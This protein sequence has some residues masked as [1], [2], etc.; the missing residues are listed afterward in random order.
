MIRVASPAENRARAQ[1][2]IVTLV[3]VLLSFLLGATVCA[4]WLNRGTQRT[5]AKPESE[6]QGTPPLELS[7]TT[8]AILKRLNSPLEIRFYSLLDPAT[9]DEATR[10]FASRT[11]Q[12]L[13][14][15]QQE[16]QGKITVAKSS[17]QSYAAA[18]AA[19]ADGVKP[20]NTEKGEPCFLGLAVLRNGQKESLS[21]LSPEWETVLEADISRAI[22]RVMDSHAPGAPA[23]TAPGIDSATAEEVKHSLTNLDSISL[24]DGTRV[25]REAALKQFKA[26]VVELQ[27]ELEQAQQELTRAQGSGSEAEQQA[28]MKHLQQVQARQSDQLKKIAL[29]A[30]AQIEVLKQL[31]AGKQ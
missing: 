30:Q 1:V 28:A 14:A 17:S 13:A 7:E 23:M 10:A 5:A 18:N 22:L 31:K 29:D 15:Y 9:V 16:A 6:R 19:T 20:F 4:L 8:K 24:E 12:L 11:E 25:L 3:V 26:K 21:N 2:S 27:H